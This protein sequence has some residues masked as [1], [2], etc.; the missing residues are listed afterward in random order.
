MSSA[1]PSSLQALAPTTTGRLVVTAFLLAC[2]AIPAAT[3]EYTQYIVNLMLVYVLVGTGFNLVIGYLGQ[4]AFANAALFGIGAYAT[5]ILMNRVNAPFV[6]AL[7]VAGFAGLLVGALISVPA[8]R[9][10]RLFYLAIITMA[11]G[12]LL[13]F[14]YI[15]AE[16]L[17]NGSTGLEVPRATLFGISLQTQS[18]LFYVFLVVT[19]LLVAGTRNLLRSRIGRA[20]CAVRDNELAAATVAIPTSWYFVIAFAWSGFVV[21]IAGGLFAVLIGRVVPE[22]FNLAQLI[23]HFAI[24]IVGGVGTLLG[25]ILARSC[26][27]PSPSCSGPS[28]APTRRSSARS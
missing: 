7:P 26:S 4:L 18:S 23:L 21:G 27:P 1:Q 22:S 11:F 10:V 20:I 19:I 24:V 14:S 5:A 15:H 8:L 25:P 16:G 2:F 12:E 3:N 28:L 17:T 6:I 9:G 13:R